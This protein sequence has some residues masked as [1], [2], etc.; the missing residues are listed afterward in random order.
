MDYPPY[1]IVIATRNR[2]EALRLSIPR[3][4]SQSI[5]PSQLIVVDSSDDH[6]ATIEAVN[7]ACRDSEL[8]PTVIKAA[9]GLTKQRNCGLA[10]V[11]NPI[12]FF[13]DDDSI[14]FPGVAQRTLDVYR[15][16]TQN[17]ISA[18][19]GKEST[20]APSDF[21]VNASNSSGYKMSFKDRIRQKLIFKRNS[22]EKKYFNDPAKALGTYYIDRAKSPD[23]F[24]EHDIA[25]VE[26]MTGFRMSFRTEVIRKHLFDETFSNYSLN[27]DID[28]SFS[29]WK[30]GMVVA[31]HKAK[32]YHY[33]SPERRDNGFRLGFQTI[34]NKAYIIAK[35]CP[36]SLKIRSTL[37]RY[38]KYKTFLYYLARRDMFSKDRYRGAKEAL[39]HLQKIIDSAETTLPSTYQSIVKRAD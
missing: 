29:A 27:E 33:K 26:Y 21:V 32:V 37:T 23:W 25:P 3:M 24:A 1:S 19:C 8:E 35:H 10:C 14:W 28:A 38:S 31:A 22:L 6:K 12:V 34:T 4:L 7:S 39:A 16:D 11:N 18:V 36:P 20:E 17:Q 9:R 5:A 30:E 2:P 13:P 15:L